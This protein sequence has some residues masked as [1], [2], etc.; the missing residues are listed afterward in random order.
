[1]CNVNPVWLLNKYSTPVEKGMA[2]IADLLLTNTKQPGPVLI[3]QL[4]FHVFHSGQII[5]KPPGEYTSNYREVSPDNRADSYMATWR[6]I[7]TK[8]PVWRQLG[9][10]LT[11]AIY[12]C[13]RSIAQCTGWTADSYL[14]KWRVQL[15]EGIVSDLIREFEL[16]G[17]QRGFSAT[18]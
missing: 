1:M 5:A 14:A 6:V 3:H 2:T 11:F 7:P 8:I 9:T 16:R 13:Y 4:T 17:T 10:A 18:L 15:T 12:M